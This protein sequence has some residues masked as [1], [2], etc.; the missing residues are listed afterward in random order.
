MSFLVAGKGA[1][2]RVAL[3]HSTPETCGERRDGH[4]FHIPDDGDPGECSHDDRG[5][6]DEQRGAEAGPAAPERPGDELAGAERSERAADAAARRLAPIAER[7]PDQEPRPGGQDE[8]GYEKCPGRS[9]HAG[10]EDADRHAE[11]R[12]HADPVP[13]SHGP[14]RSF[15]GPAS[16]QTTRAAPPQPESGGSP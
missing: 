2:S 13:A 15:G 10:E 7:E 1:Q 8:R 9:E 12:R 16:G 14:E 4:G 6:A 3:G 11:P 5:S